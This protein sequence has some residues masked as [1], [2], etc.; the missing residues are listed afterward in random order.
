M[1]LWPRFV[2]WT[3]KSYP[4]LNDPQLATQTATLEMKRELFTVNII[5]TEREINRAVHQHLN[6][7]PT[8]VMSVHSNFIKRSLR[9]ITEYLI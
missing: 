4:M 2:K 1:W 8:S 7:S 5:D 6:Y 9:P 3:V